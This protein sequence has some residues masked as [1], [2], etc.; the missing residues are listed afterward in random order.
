M[1][2]G[3]RSERRLSIQLSAFVEPRLKEAIR[4]AAKDADIYVR[5][6]ALA[7]MLD[8]ETERA[9]AQKQLHTIAKGKEPSAL[10]ALAAL[11]AAGDGS[12][13]GALEKALARKSSQERVLV[14]RSLIRI[15]IYARVATLLADDDPD[16]RTRV[17]C[18]VLIAQ[19]RAL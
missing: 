12:V 17:A 8:D 11:A 15:G 13:E 16:V 19:E 7:R 10:Q 14:A 6:M 5:L 1:V 4:R 9:I 3:T 2:D 18:N